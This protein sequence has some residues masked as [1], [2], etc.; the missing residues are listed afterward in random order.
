MTYAIHTLTNSSPSTGAAPAFEPIA[1]AP[2][3][4]RADAVDAEVIELAGRVERLSRRCDAAADRRAKI[5]DRVMVE[6]PRRP[7]PPAPPPTRHTVLDQHT[8]TERVVTLTSPLDPDPALIEW[9][10]VRE[11][12]EEEHKRKV[13]DLEARLGLPDLGKRLD[14]M[15]CRLER[16]AIQL[17]VMGPKTPAGLAAK[18]AASVAIMETDSSNAWVT[19]LSLAVGRDTVR[20]NPPTGPAPGDD[21]Y[22]PESLGMSERRELSPNDIDVIDTAKL[23]ISYCGKNVGA[24]LYTSEV[25]ATGSCLTTKTP[26]SLIALGVKGDRLPMGPGQ[27]RRRRQVGSASRCGCGPGRSQSRPAVGSA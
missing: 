1:T 21:L 15:F 6:G 8:A 7:V 14:R 10:R 20:L 3:T 27:R 4:P 11:A 2:F 16:W 5:E 25:G 13:A 19:D 24:R 9:E 12:S 17:T 23:L 18:A 26:A 22:G